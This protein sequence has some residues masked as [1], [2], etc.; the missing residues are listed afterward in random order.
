MRGNISLY[1]ANNEHL[2]EI[3]KTNYQQGKLVFQQTYKDIT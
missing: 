1:L 2:S 3:G